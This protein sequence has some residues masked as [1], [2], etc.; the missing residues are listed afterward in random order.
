MLSLLRSP[1]ADPRG[2]VYVAEN[3]FSPGLVKI[4]MTQRAPGAR[5]QE[6][7]TAT[8]VPGRQLR[9]IEAFAVN[10]ASQAEARAH[11]VLSSARVSGSEWF[12]IEAVE[13]SRALKRALAV[14]RLSPRRS[15]LRRAVFWLFRTVLSGVL[16]Y[17]ALI[18]L[19]SS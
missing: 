5:V 6:L 1:P 4:G 16:S 12:R 15:L 13:A 14:D 3:P 19:F 11:R 17:G 2:Y 7:A 8:G 10:D 18:V 9:L